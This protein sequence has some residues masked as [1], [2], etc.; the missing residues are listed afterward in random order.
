MVGRNCSIV[1]KS[2][3]SGQWPIRPKLTGTQQ[4][5]DMLE[6]NKLNANRSQKQFIRKPKIVLLLQSNLCGSS[7][8]S[9]SDPAK[10][11]SKLQSPGTKAVPCLQAI[12]VAA[13]CYVFSS[14]CPS[15]FYCSPFLEE[16]L[17]PS[18]GELQDFWSAD[19]MQRDIQLWK[20]DWSLGT[21]L[22]SRCIIYCVSGIMVNDLISLTSRLKPSFNV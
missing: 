22:K 1:C 20:A 17:Q 3:N 12:N 9:Y 14:W 15:W 5:K 7:N 11:P 18:H 8:R 2:L 19:G 21:S 16:R 13:G 4:L 10:K 6:E